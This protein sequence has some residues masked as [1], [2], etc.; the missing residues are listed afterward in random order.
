[1]AGR[2]ST[3]FTTIARRLDGLLCNR[4][5]F[6]TGRNG[7]DE[8]CSSRTT[9][10]LVGRNIFI[11]TPTATTTT[12]TG[13]DLHLLNGSRAF[14]GGSRGGT[15]DIFAGLETIVAQ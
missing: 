7:N 8:G 4:I 15:V 3:T 5:V 10:L 1:M 14:Y 9:S 6:N 13:N 12:T 2:S 11:A